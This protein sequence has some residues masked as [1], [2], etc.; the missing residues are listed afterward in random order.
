[1]TQLQVTYAVA[2]HFGWLVHE[3]YIDAKSDSA[4]LDRHSSTFRSGWRTEAA[5]RPQR[6]ELCKA[7]LQQLDL[8]DVDLSGAIIASSDL[9]GVVLHRSRL[10][11]TFINGSTLN[12]IQAY[13]ANFS[14]VSA[15]SA[16][17][18]GA[19][20]SRANLQS[21]DLSDSKLL[22]ETA[23]HQCMQPPDFA[24][25]D[26]LEKYHATPTHL[27]ASDLSNAQFHSAD[28]RCTLLGQTN[29][30]QTD[31]SGATMGGAALTEV[32][33]SDT[34]FSRV[35]M[36]GL[37][38]W[39]LSG[40]PDPFALGG[41]RGLWAVR[42]FPHQQAVVVALR[43]QL[44]D[45]G[46]R[47]SEREATY[48]IEHSVTQEDLRS[49]LWTFG[50]LLGWIRYLGLEVPTGYGLYPES[51]LACIALFWALFT[52]LYV[53]VILSGGATNAIIQRFPQGRIDRADQYDVKISG[54][55]VAYRVVAR[56]LLSA[57]RSAAYF[58]LM[59]A[60]NIGFQQ[61]T[62]GDWVRRVQLRDYTL[63]GIGIGR[64]LAG[65]QALLGVYLLAL[66]VLTRFGRPF[67]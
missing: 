55:S 13:Q 53:L 44:L 24:A 17:F 63:E 41:I 52:P 43:K 45:D 6:A 2:W 67:Q 8:S 28:M 32:H 5:V 23:Q 26:T 16:S 50:W 10:V 22:P 58:S 64:S 62:P 27:D 35:E 42:I 19:D 21:A 40:S 9:T 15:D 47:D 49:P 54:E 61:V 1:M 14:H 39:P 48:A 11:G 33:L 18:C 46:L 4:Y 59:S 12:G 3:G 34:K 37:Y 57:W 20:L 66:W 36:S 25:C 31:F 51:A 56:S 65:T 30:T 38:Y 60:I 7:Q 29:L